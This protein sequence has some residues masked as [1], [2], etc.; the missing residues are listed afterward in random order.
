MAAKNGLAGMSKL[1]DHIV[2][3]ALDLAGEDGWDAVRLRRVAD[4]LGLSL[5]A[6]S[7]EFRD[8]DAVANAWFSRAT[9]AMLAPP[10]RGFAGRPAAE[11][12]ERIMLRWF[13]ALAPHRAVTGGM[14]TAKLHPPHPHH[15]MPLIFDLS[16][17]VQWLRE[18]ALLDA[19]GRRRQIEEI[20]LT[21]LF[22]VTLRYWLRD[23]SPGQEMTRAF[24]ARRLARADSLV[25]R[26]WPPGPN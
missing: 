5:A 1:R 4:R 20:G 12:I 23:E 14:L 10:P 13:D 2:D 26:L 18:A 24:L 9:A 21:A 19:T 16:R 17:T 6:V 25:A 22:L 15:W 3:T 11:R 7:A 8:A